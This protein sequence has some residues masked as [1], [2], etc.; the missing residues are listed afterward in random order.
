L[1][2]PLHAG[3]RQAGI[4]RRRRP[5]HLKKIHRA[6]EQTPFRTGMAGA[7]GVVIGI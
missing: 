6:A 2:E 4:H 1:P 3:P 5:N 7:D